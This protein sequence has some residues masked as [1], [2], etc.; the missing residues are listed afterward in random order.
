MG[1]GRGPTSSP[2]GRLTKWVI[3]LSEFDV[4][5]RP[6]P[7]IKAQALA[8]FIVETSFIEPIRELINLEQHL[9]TLHVDGAVNQ[10][11]C[12]AGLVL[13]TDKGLLTKFALTLGFAATNNEAEYEALIAG[14][15]IALTSSCERLECFC[16]SEVIVNQVQG[17]YE[18][19][20]GLLPQYHS[21]A[22][23][24]LPRFK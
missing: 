4:V 20:T 19:R 8:D 2:S 5:Y 17:N 13:K 9:W 12:G 22:T 14:L 10:D 11:G 18:A 7:A 15:E 21:R 24:L 1:L 3:E 6:R 23:A 16:D